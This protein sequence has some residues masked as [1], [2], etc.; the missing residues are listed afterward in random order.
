M[1]F[2]MYIIDFGLQR[3]G[4]II[5]YP[6]AFVKRKK[7]LGLAFNKTRNLVMEVLARY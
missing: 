6:Y 4:S 3:L 1:Y 2:G 5:G 7:K